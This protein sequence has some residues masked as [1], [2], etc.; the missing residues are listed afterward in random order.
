MPAFKY[1][2][3]DPNGKVIRGIMDTADR[4]SILALFRER[5]YRVVSVDEATML[6]TAFQR[7]TD[8]FFGVSRNHVIL[9]TR[10]LSTL[11]RSGL[12][13]TPALESLALQERNQK[14]RLVIETV[15]GEI[16]KGKSFSDAL[17]HYPR[18]FSNL[19]V[20]MVKAGEAAGILDEVL[21]RLAR[22][23][24]Q[25]ME[26]RTKLQATLTYPVI[27]VGVAMLVLG[28][29]L[30]SAI[31]KFLDIFRASQAELPLATVILL[32]VSKVFRQFWFVIVIA[33]IGLGFGISRYR[34][35]PAGRHVLDRL[36]LRLPIFGEAYLKI[37]LVRLTRSLSALTKS[38][39]PLLN[40][41]EI[42]KALGSNAVVLDALEQIQLGISQGKSLTDL[43]QKSGI[44][45]PM[46][47]Q[48]VSV[49][50]NTGRLDEMLAEVANFYELE[51]EYFLRN[52][53]S[54]LEPIL[55]LVMGLMV[56]FIALAVLMPIFNLVK[57]FR[58]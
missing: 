48:M 4:F 26:I 57:V 56:G 22:L 38:G 32:G 35:T 2:V 41:V 18:L 21:E 16:E 24:V 55:L 53:T 40:A 49:G 19:Y 43:F 45:P 58:S 29:L 6:D 52:L 44:F 46:V 37:I 50:E 11:I 13:L 17:S 33:L 3:R 12:Q 1:V 34:E 25:E 30:V 8:Y 47:V 23:G 5:N 51:M 9:F 28:F 31:P 15:K 36:L 14:F 20:G 54:S 39:I 27:L 10:Q 7:S 42:T